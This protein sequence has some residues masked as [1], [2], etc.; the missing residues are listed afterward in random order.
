ML[1]SCQIEYEYGAIGNTV[2]CGRRSVAQCADCGISL[3][4]ECSTGCCGESFCGCCYDFHVTETC[5]RKP[6]KA[7]VLIAMRGF[8]IMHLERATGKTLPIRKPK[9]D[10]CS[11]CGKSGGAEEAQTD[12]RGNLVHEPCLVTRSSINNR[13]VHALDSQRSSSK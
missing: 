8:G 1:P 13:A 6:T 3:C 5:V 4:S 12:E 9:D 10:R 2:R 7:D 11:I